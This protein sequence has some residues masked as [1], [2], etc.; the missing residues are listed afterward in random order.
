M[1]L[2]TTKPKHIVAL[3]LMLLTVLLNFILP[4]L[5]LLATNQ[6]TTSI[7]TPNALEEFILFSIQIG[8]VVL[9]LLLIPII[10]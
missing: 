2:N 5:A 6:T 8:S 3:F 4:G 10:W 1:D 7:P 9:T